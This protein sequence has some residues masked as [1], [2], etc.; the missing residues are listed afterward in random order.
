MFSVIRR[1]TLYLWYFGFSLSPVGQGDIESVC[2]I[3]IL[4]WLQV[5]IG[6]QPTNPNAGDMTRRVLS[7][8]SPGMVY[9]VRCLVW[10]VIGYGLSNCSIILA[11]YGDILLGEAD[12]GWVWLGCGPLWC[13]DRLFYCLA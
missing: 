10:C 2:V 6:Q 4:L 7:T 12:Q 13:L 8:G 3:Y 1:I 9:N 11:I 5:C